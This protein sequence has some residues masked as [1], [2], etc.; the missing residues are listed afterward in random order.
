MNKIKKNIIITKIRKI[1]LKEVKCPFCKTITYINC[2]RIKG[3]KHCSCK[4][5][6]D[7]DS[8]NAIFVIENNQR[9]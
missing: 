5:L 6:D 1:K 4:H 7:Y 8:K 9:L 3:T 2:V